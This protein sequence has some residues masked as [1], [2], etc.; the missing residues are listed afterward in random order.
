MLC[1]EELNGLTSALQMVRYLPGKDFNIIVVSIDPT[2]GTDWPRPR[3]ALTSSATAALK[4]P[5][6]GT[7]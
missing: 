6:A 2:E 5:T 4:P 7:S 3:S 1:S